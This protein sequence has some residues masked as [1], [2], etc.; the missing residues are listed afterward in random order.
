MDCSKVGQLIYKLRKEKNMTQKE[1]AEQLNISDKTISKWER[2]MGCPDVSLL[3]EL[4]NI[5]GVEIEKI[6]TGELNPNEK[7]NGNMKHLKFYTC[8]E[9]GNVMTG[10]GNASLSCCGR[11][12]EPLQ[13]QPA[14]GEHAVTVEN[15]EDEY[16]LTLDHEMSKEHYISFVALVS[17]DHLLL[18]KLYPE[19]NAQLRMPRLHRSAALYVYCT[20]H[21]LFKHEKL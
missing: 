14:D 20:Q 12:L 10:T 8:P 18:V 21:G 15:M 9:C 4:S 3:G 5:L 13:A 17:Y 7:D 19:Q 1:L 2:G 11:I 6:L 16:Y